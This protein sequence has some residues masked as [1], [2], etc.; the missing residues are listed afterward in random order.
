MDIGLYFHIPFCHSKC[1]Y[2]D[3]LSFAKK[4]NQEQYIDALIKE[5][6][7]TSQSLPPDTQITTL[8]IG[9]G[10][11]TVLSPALIDK[12]FKGIMTYFNLTPDC[13]WTIESNP[14]TLDEEKIRVMK[15]YPVTRISMGLQSTH[16]SLL[17]KTGRRHCFREWQESLALVRKYTKWQVN[18][19]LMFA[20]PGQTFEDF[21]QTLREIIPYQLEHLSIYALI[22]E[23]GTVFGELYN[24][25]QL[26]EVSEE[27]DR[28]MYHYAQKF[29][30]EQGYKQYE[31]SN[32]A[33][34]GKECM[35]NRVYWTLKPYIGLGLGAHSYYQNRRFFNVEDLEKYITAQGNLNKLRVE[36]E[37]VS[38]Q[39]AME[40]YLFLGLRMIQ[41]VSKKDF[42]MRFNREIGEVY[43][44]QIA[45]WLE[46]G[47]LKEDNE[48]YY[49]SSYGLD[50]CNEVFASFIKE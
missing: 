4:N 26:K 5:M 13:E 9:G 48:T 20:L 29:L 27:L 35:H 23:E 15:D 37:I 2:C 49:L 38:T 47:L 8:F 46:M 10:T 17:K 50:V 1:Y 14:G 28:Q 40:E 19:D 3:F 24:K 25:G 22:I 34:E 7:H 30:K 31:I 6:A 16:D 32:W 41:G 21:E 44:D 39:K 12:L 18:A 42:K 36:E 11:P 43:P 45:H 33:Y